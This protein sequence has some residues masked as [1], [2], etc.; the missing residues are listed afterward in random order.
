MSLAVF[1]YGL[2]KVAGG[3]MRLFKGLMNPKLKM[4]K[5]NYSAVIGAH[6]QMAMHH[7][8]P[9]DGGI[10]AKDLYRH[11]SP[12]ERGINRLATSTHLLSGMTI[13]TDFEKAASSHYINSELMTAMKNV[14]LG[15][16]TTKQVDFL[17]QNYISPDMAVDMMASFNK[18]GGGD[19]VDGHMLPNLD[20]WTKEQSTIMKAAVARESGMV[21]LETGAEKPIW[22]SSP[23]GSLFGQFKSF[24]A[25]FNTRV[26]LAQL[27]QADANTVSG[28]FATIAMG[29]FI[30]S[31]H[32]II[33][34]QPMHKN[35]SE[36]LK[37]GIDR[38]GIT[39]WFGEMNAITSKLT[40]GQA[41]FYRLIGAHQPLTRYASRGL[42]SSLMGPAFG[43]ATDA[44]GLAYAASTGTWSDQDTRTLRRT[45]V[46]YQNIFYLNRLF[47]QVE[48][49][50][51]N[52][53]G[54]PNKIDRS[55]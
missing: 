50:V 12:A 39:G 47:T 9:G 49:G 46:P 2:F 15:K 31:A 38:S 28:I 17:R 21:T 4:P 37:A 30:D 48:L 42:V 19:I 36:L 25:A 20:T 6:T 10:S 27:Q 22:M 33:K 14:A 51:N 54:I 45:L 8:L 7:V 35:P 41:D 1:R 55:K 29:M 44:T 16:G 52:A 26:M 23:I 32:R 13:V 40:G 34:G 3:Y 18:P 24:I 53:F 11:V 5:S 43:K